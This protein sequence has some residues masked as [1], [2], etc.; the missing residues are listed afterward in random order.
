MRTYREEGSGR[1]AGEQRGRKIINTIKQE[2]GLAG[3]M[4]T[5][6]YHVEKGHQLNSCAYLGFKKKSLG[7]ENHRCR[8]PES[9]T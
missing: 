9:V 8:D 3:K 7:R 6:A 4:R 1:R 2:Q 5:I